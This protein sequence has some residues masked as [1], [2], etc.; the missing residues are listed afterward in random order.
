MIGKHIPSPKSN[1]SF[2]GLND[3]ISGKSKR[4]LNTEKVAFV[5]CVNLLST[6]TATAEMESLALQNKR[7]ADPVMHL[8]LSWRTNENPTREQVREGQDRLTRLRA[9]TLGEGYD[10]ESIQAA[11]EYRV[12]PAE[13]RAG[14]PRKVNL[15]VDIQAKMRAGKGPA[16]EMR[17]ANFGPTW[18]E[19]AGF[20][21]A[22]PNK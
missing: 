14:G 21:A 9:S 16:Y 20:G 18:P 2:A 19:V 8:L 12:A 22:G 6:E 10:P 17:S 11:I 1:S 15:I 7:C 4:R 13:D 5:D 3:Y